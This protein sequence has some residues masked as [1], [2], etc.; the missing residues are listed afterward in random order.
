[1]SQPRERSIYISRQVF[2]CLLALAKAKDTTP[3]AI[4]ER[5]LEQ[6]VQE[7]TPSVWDFYASHQK[8][9]AALIDSVKAFTIKPTTT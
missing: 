1:M 8:A 5:L 7:S 4:A 3:D 6:A 2:A 9:E